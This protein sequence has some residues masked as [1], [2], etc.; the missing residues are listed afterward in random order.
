[1]LPVPGSPSPTLPV[2]WRKS[3][4]GWLAASLLAVLATAGPGAQADPVTPSPGN[5]WIQ[6]CADPN[7]VLQDKEDSAKQ[8]SVKLARLDKSDETEQWI[9]SPGEK[10]GS[11]TLTN[12]K[13]NLVLAAQGNSVTLITQEKVTSHTTWS[14]A[15]LRDNVMALRPNDNWDLNL[16][17]DGS[18]K[19]ALRGWRNGQPDETWYLVE[20]EP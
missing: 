11:V 10:E 12:A 7:L 13:S 15:N 3:G 20:A 9:L 5:Y 6:S 4:R 17:V 2:P 19:V 14:F 8:H 16:N 18:A 1:M